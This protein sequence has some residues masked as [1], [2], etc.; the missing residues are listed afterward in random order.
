VDQDR[1][2]IFRRIACPIIPPQNEAYG[3]ASVDDSVYIFG[4]RQSMNGI[5]VFTNQLWV[6]RPSEPSWRLARTVNTPP[7]RWGHT[8]TSY[9]GYIFLF[10]GSQIGHTYNDLWCINSEDINRALSMGGEASWTLLI[11]V[12]AGEVM[13][14]GAPCPRGGHAAVLMVRVVCPV[15]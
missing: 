6:Y 11:D 2:I 15:H 5:Q 3:M 1:S 4:G 14:E 13:A 9:R 8:I 12:A 7:P 10:G